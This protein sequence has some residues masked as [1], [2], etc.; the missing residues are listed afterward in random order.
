[1]L[2]YFA[3]GN[4]VSSSA[5]GAFSPKSTQMKKRRRKKK[6]GGRGQ[7]VSAGDVVEKLGCFLGILIF[8]PL[9]PYLLRLLGAGFSA[10]LS[11][12]ITKR[13]EQRYHLFFEDLRATLS[14]VERKVGLLL[15]I[16]YAIVL[17][18]AILACILA[19]AAVASADSVT[20]WQGFGGVVFLVCLVYG[21]GGAILS[22]LALLLA[23]LCRSTFARLSKAIILESSIPPWSMTLLH[24][25]TISSIAYATIYHFSP[26]HLEFTPPHFELQRPPHSSSF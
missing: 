11:A 4:D 12:C 19:V 1:M 10:D 24:L 23:L 15:S 8:L 3:G 18:L 9:A 21:C 13:I 22:A 14:P 20:A 7:G 17:V 5:A 25:L 6:G 2:F 16:G 26:S